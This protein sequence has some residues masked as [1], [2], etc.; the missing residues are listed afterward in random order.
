MKWLLQCGLPV[1]LQVVALPSMGCKGLP[2]TILANPSIH[3][4]VLPQDLGILSP[5]T[6]A[7]IIFA[8]DSVT[9]SGS[10]IP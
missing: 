2:L 10:Q 3:C 6:G 7:V 1:G 9:L 4:S 5:Y 8:R